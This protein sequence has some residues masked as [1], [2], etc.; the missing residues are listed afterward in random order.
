M[1]VLLLGQVQRGVGQMEVL[2]TSPAIGEALDA[3]FA[4]DAQKR[5]MV[6]FFDAGAGG[7]RGVDDGLRPRGPSG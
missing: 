5:P 1:G 6:P 3:H 4:E 7:P 2:L